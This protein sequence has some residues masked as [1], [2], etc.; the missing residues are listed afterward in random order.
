MPD[1]RQSSL[2]CQNLT[3]DTDT[4]GSLSEPTTK[5]LAYG[6]RC[7]MDSAEAAAEMDKRQTY[8]NKTTRIAH[9]L[10]PQRSTVRARIR[11]VCPPRTSTG[12]SSQRVP[13]HFHF[14]LQ[15]GSS[16]GKQKRSS[17]TVAEPKRPYS[18]RELDQSANHNTPRGWGHQP[19]NQPTHTRRAEIEN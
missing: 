19:T 3:S 2:Q 4:C 18:S 9:H 1:P 15:Y 7:R 17:L 6:E 16:V 12:P 10:P 11:T 13:H 14:W 5:D 8:E